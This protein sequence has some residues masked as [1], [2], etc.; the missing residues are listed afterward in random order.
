MELGYRS[1]MKKILGA[2]CA[3]ALLLSPAARAER[4]ELEA[5]PPFVQTFKQLAV[6]ILR[7][8][9]EGTQFVGSGF[10]WVR[11][12]KV[13]VITNAHVAQLGLA[14]EPP[15]GGLHVGFAGPLGWHAATTVRN[16]PEADLAVIE[17]PVTAPQGNPYALGIAHL[18]EEIYSISF[19]E[20][21][22]QQDTP[23]IH[24][25][26]VIAVTGALFPKSILVPKPPFP[27]DAV[28]V[29]LI[30]GTNCLPGTSGSMMLN[31]RGQLVAYHAGAIEGGLCVAVA[32]DELERF[33]AR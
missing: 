8:G 15:R 14:P 27:P 4:I 7:G 32:I 6:R 21:E 18:G 28:A 3:L 19:S 13:L 26:R 5:A 31:S 9:G 33:L 1:G 25:G 11:E 23:V 12:G 22:F 16:L 10:A 20:R 30:E 24:K 29:Y 2:A 17:T